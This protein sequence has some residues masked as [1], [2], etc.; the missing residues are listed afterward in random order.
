MKLRL[1]RLLIGVPILAS[2]ALLSSAAARAPAA[3]PQYAD[4]ECPSKLDYVVLA[5]FAD[6]SNLLAMSAYRA[7]LKD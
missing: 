4:S 3:P 5:S 2:I 6:S 1:G 7:P